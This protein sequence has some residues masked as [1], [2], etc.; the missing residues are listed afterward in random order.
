MDSMYSSNLPSPSNVQ[1]LASGM[2]LHDEFS[3]DEGSYTY[4][5]NNR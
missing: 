3:V 5:K 1:E 4:N 2:L